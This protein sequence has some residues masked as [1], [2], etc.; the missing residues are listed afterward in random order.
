MLMEEYIISE[1]LG[2]IF[3]AAW[4]VI[5]YFL[6]GK[7]IY[8]YVKNKYYELGLYEADAD[9]KISGIA[10]IATI[11]F[12]ILS[13][14]DIGGISS[15]IAS[16]LTSDPLLLFLLPYVLRWLSAT[17]IDFIFCIVAWHF[18]LRQYI[19]NSIYA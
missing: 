17:I 1:I 15:N 19:E 16:Q 12:M 8:G 10:W 13:T 7:N 3:P 2:K 4:P 18:Y 11:L 9:S 5:S 14:F 6:F